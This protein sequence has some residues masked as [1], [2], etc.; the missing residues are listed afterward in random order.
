M[1]NASLSWPITL[2]AGI[3]ILVAVRLILMMLLNVLFAIGIAQDV[4]RRWRRGQDTVLVYPAVWVIATL[5]GG[6][7]VAGLYWLIHHSMLSPPQGNRGTL[8]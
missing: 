2:Q 3:P 1:N 5:L 6:I 4:D 7:Y 8:P